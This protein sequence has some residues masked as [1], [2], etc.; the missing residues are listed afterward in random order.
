MMKKAENKNPAAILGVPILLG[1]IA[2]LLLMAIGAL[3]VLCGRMA[4]TTI[5]Q[6]VLIAIAV[7]SALTGLIA[8][9]RAV[10]NKLLWGL[11]GGLGLYICLLLISFLWIGEPVR[12]VRVLLTGAVAILSAAG[13]AIAGASR[14]KQKKQR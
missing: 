12:L 13:G 3:L 8:A 4:T 11:A 2:L 10:H 5:L 9:I 1:L 7:C 14:R 6:F